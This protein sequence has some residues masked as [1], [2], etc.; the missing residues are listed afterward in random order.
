MR[1]IRLLLPL[2]S[3]ALGVATAAAGTSFTVTVD[4]SKAGTA[5]ACT[6]KPATTTDKLDA[7]TVTVVAKQKSDLQLTVDA[8]V[9]VLKADTTEVKFPAAAF[10]NKSLLV[11]SSGKKICDRLLEPAVAT[12][13]TPGAP[14]TPSTP[15]VE[16]DKSAL[17]VL[18]QAART[19]LE[20]KNLADHQVTRQS[21]FGRT[22]RIYHLPTG[23]PAFPLPRHVNEKDDLEIWTV[24]PSDATVSIE[25]SAC[26][27][28]PAVRVGGTYK[29]AKEYAASLQSGEKAQLTFKL[30]GY[31]KRLNCAG[32][33]TY[34]VDVAHQGMAAS[35][36]TSVAFDPVYRFEWGVGFMFDFARPRKLSLG[37]RPT[38]DGMG[39]IGSEKFV[40]ESDDYTGF[41]PV[42]TLGIN[43]C[44]TNPEQM[45]WCDRLLNP[46]LLVDPTRL[47]SGF[48]LG[49]TFR[50]FHGFGVLAGM[51]VFKTTTFADGAMV[52]VG[53]PWSIAGDLPTK[54]VFNKDSLGFVLSAVVSTDVFAALKKSE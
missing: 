42:I 2:T 44:G 27:K 47:T 36:T 17:A 11:M 40:I 28:V 3:L 43:V 54:E 32:T 18:D 37:D 22:F 6:S 14:G 15:P 34:K 16:V 4:P 46:T 24:V 29:A 12:P 45:T 23:A 41:K 38:D 30:D 26:D 53:D 31:S 48:G 35:T 39:T 51:T 13:G 5:E 33:L 49:L 52:V 50:P 9:V 7:L 19:F 10:L 21:N 1:S 25:V 20:G 8:S